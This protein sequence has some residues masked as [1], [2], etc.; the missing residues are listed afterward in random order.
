MISVCDPAIFGDVMRVNNF[1]ATTTAKS[2]AEF[3]KT[4]W[5][6]LLEL[7]G[8]DERGGEEIRERDEGEERGSRQ[9]KR[10]EGERGERGGEEKRG[11]RIEK[12]DE[13]KS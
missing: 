13:R 5:Q 1:H 11:E 3:G 7:E 8:G 9:K 6:E 12:R 2:E 10:G 4:W